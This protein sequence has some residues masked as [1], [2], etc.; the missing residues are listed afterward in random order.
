MRVK[1][2]KNFI[3]C[4]PKQ[5][6]FRFYEEKPKSRTLGQTLQQRFGLKRSKITHVL[7]TILFVFNKILGSVKAQH[8]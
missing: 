6:L 8:V 5:H 4:V 3:N 2:L 7:A 1:V